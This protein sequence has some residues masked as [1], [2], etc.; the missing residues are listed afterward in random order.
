MSRLRACFVV[1]RFLRFLWWFDLCFTRG[2]FECAQ[3]RRQ[4]TPE[5]TREFYW[6]GGLDLYVAR[7]AVSMLLV[8]CLFRG[9]IFFGGVCLRVFVLLYSL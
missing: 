5:K 2:V 8:A 9:A 3:S 4:S 7:L 1:M 6:I